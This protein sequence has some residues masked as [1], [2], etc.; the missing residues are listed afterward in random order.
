M[1]YSY[2][3]ASDGK[4][5]PKSGT[6][7]AQFPKANAYSWLKAPRLNNKPAEAGPLARMTMTDGKNRGVSVLA[8]HIARAEEALYVAKALPGWLDQLTASGAVYTRSSVPTGTA[9]GVGLT[10]APR[11]AIGHWV[12][13]SG[14]KVSRYQ[15]ITPTCWNAS[16]RDGAGLKGPLE[17]A[18][19]STPVQNLDEP[20]EVLRVIHSFDP[21]L[22][23]AVHVSRPSEGAKIFSVPHTHGEELDSCGVQPG[24]GHGHSHDHDHEHSHDHTH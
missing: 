7:T 21:C 14:G 12:D 23:C 11:G 18:L 19:I 6:T 1:D 5:A 13:L 17:K 22:S 4:K 2:Y 8:R 15:I 20:V 10:E 16:P 24:A 3:A 9:S